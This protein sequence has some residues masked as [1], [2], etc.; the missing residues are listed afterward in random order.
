MLN[1]WKKAGWLML[2][3]V[4]LGAQAAITDVDLA[5]YQL[6]GNYGLALTTTPKAWEASAVTF[7]ADNGH[8]YVIEDEARRVYEISKTGSVLSSMTLVGFDGDAENKGDTEGLTYVGGGQFVMA[9]E[10][11]QSLYRFTYVPGGTL[12]RDPSQEVALGPHVGNVGIEGVSYDPSTGQFVTVKEKSPEQVNLWDINF[13]THGAVGG[14]L[15][16]PSGLGLLD[17]ADVQ[18]LSTVTS[19]TGTADGQNLLLLSQES[20]RLLEVSRSGAVL[21]MYDLASLSGSI[22]GVT[23]DTE[24]NIYLVSEEVTGGDPHLF[25][26]SPTPVPLPAGIWLLGSGVAAMG[27]IRRRRASTKLI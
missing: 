21:S 5:N 18:A 27:A 3:C 23:I 12:I 15:F 19:L 1:A 2:A 8:L 4:S 20:R 22:E 6:T 13:S 16:D 7:N 25:V 17:I 24:G 11:I 10:R 14:P 9:E 26:L